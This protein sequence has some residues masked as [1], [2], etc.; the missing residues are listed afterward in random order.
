[1]GV[2]YTHGGRLGGTHLQVLNLQTSYFPRRIS[3]CINPREYS[4]N[5][6]KF[7]FFLVFRLLFAIMAANLI[8]YVEPSK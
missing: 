5:I 8:N 6:S 3:L 7:Y 2:L 4:C 1:M